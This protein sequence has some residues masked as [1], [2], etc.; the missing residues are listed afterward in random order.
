M[1]INAILYVLISTCVVHH[2]TLLAASIND[3]QQQVVNAQQQNVDIQSQIDQLH[4]QQ[5]QLDRQYQSLLV[6]LEDITSNNNKLEL[7]INTQ[8]QRINSFNQQLESITQI[9]LQ[10]QP[11]MTQ[12]Q[13]ALA[14][15]VS[16]DLPFLP[17]RRAAALE[18]LN[19]SL[20][21]AESVLA[22]QYL[23]LLNAYKDEAAYASDIE[24]YQDNI[25]LNNTDTQV[26][27]FRL[28]RT[29]LYYQTLDRSNSAHWSK[30]SNSWQVL[31]NKQNSLL[32][33]AISSADG[34]SVP[35]LLPLPFAD[36]QSLSESVV[37]QGAKQ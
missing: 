14:Q 5:Q 27:M 36:M 34:S 4:T 6:E 2:S 23:A 10:I 8:V 1:K 21:D 9:E 26:N 24:V 13:L 19:E 11:L 18:Q 12:M 7:R 3:V 28:G 32:T 35:R 37:N 31:S 17:V 30:K 25:M 29:A 22:D 15:F 33:E 16:A 20:L